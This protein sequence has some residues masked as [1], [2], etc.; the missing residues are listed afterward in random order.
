LARLLLAS[1][2]WLPQPNPATA[3]R[4]PGRQGT[5]QVRALLERLPASGVVPWFMFDGGYDSAQLSLDLAEERVALGV[6][7]RSRAPAFCEFGWL[8]R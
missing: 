5:T 3:T 2:L 4:L 1:T 7:L 6:R 8:V